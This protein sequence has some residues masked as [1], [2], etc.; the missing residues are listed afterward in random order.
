MTAQTE[1]DR[2]RL[3]PTKREIAGRLLS[4]ADDMDAVALAMDYYGG[5]APWAQHAKEMMGAAVLCRDWAD[6]I[7]ADEPVARGAVEADD[8]RGPVRYDRINIQIRCLVQR[9]GDR[10]VTVTVPRLST[11]AWTG[12]TEAEARMMALF[13]LV[14][15]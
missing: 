5:M 12:Q 7:Q 2:S 6:E 8:V 15:A 13:D 9:N 3:A 11:K 4:L 10:S 14:D 1:I